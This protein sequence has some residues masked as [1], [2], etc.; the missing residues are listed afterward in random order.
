MPLSDGLESEGTYWQTFDIGQ[1]ERRLDLLLG[2]ETMLPPDDVSPSNIIEIL[3]ANHQAKHI[4]ANK[5]ALDGIT[6]EN[7]EK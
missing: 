2:D 6:H 4:H 5:N 3:V 7:V 1:G